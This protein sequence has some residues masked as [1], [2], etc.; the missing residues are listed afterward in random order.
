MC[1]CRHTCTADLRVLRARMCVDSTTLDSTQPSAFM[2]LLYP[3]IQGPQEFCC[4]CPTL[5]YRDPLQ[6]LLLPL[7][8]PY[9]QGPTTSTSAA[10]ILSSCASSLL[11]YQ[12]SGTLQGRYVHSQNICSLRG[13]RVSHSWPT[14]YSTQHTYNTDTEY[15]Y[16]HT[17]IHTKLHS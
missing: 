9:V 7:S 10:S 4:L 12:T 14:T 5:M 17:C 15:T 8:Y 13:P 1:T 3:D 16:I 2:C 6:A 11:S